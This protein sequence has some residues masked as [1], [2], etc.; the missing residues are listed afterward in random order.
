MPCVGFSAGR[1]GVGVQKDFNL[2]WHIWYHHLTNRV[3]IGGNSL[4]HCQRCR[5]QVAW[6]VI[7]IPANEGSKRFRRMTAQ[8][9][10]HNIV[11]RGVR[12]AERQL[13]A[14]EADELC[15]VI[16]FKYLE[17]VLLQDDNT[18]PVM[19]RSLKRAWATWA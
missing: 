7:N 19:H 17:C 10:Q 3:M 15:N 14:Y 1:G 12:T 6:I 8:Q 11:T 2:Q 13:T 18:I 9:M 4:S 5:V 16:R